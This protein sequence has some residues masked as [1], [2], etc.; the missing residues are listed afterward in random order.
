MNIVEITFDDEL[1]IMGKFSKIQNHSE[2][3]G[4]EVDGE[5]SIRQGTSYLKI[6][7]KIEKNDSTEKQISKQIGSN[8]EVSNSNDGFI[9]GFL[10]NGSYVKLDTF[11][12]SRSADSYPGFRTSQYKIL[13]LTFFKFTPIKVT[14]VF[15]FYKIDI[16][17][18]V[19]WGFFPNF[20]DDKDYSKIIPSTD[21]GKF[22]YSNFSFNLK[23]QPGILFKRDENNRHHFEIFHQL[24]FEVN[25]SIKLN[26]TSI[27]KISDELNKLISIL[28]YLPSYVSSIQCFDNTKRLLSTTIST[29]E[30]IKIPR[31]YL[32]QAESTSYFKLENE[33]PNILNSFLSRNEKLSAAISSV[34]ANISIRN[35]TESRLVNDCSTIDILEKSGTVP[36]NHKSQYFLAKIKR[37]TKSLPQEIQ[38]AFFKSDNE[39]LSFCKKVKDTRNFL[40]HGKSSKE[41]TILKDVD[42]ISA[43]ITLDWL[44]LAYV[45]N[46]LHIPL[47]NII[48]FLSKQRLSVSKD[49]II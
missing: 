24:K 7:G 22:E 9:Y 11:F 43:S 36:S 32:P 10:E 15:E 19:H 49:E 1:D 33:F 29:H 16:N 8:N 18:L 13:K 21:L 35:T 5:L 39:R 3:D 4:T 26:I 31:K 37:F 2:W 45:Y 20:F 41:P 48:D 23:L 42:L 6:L 17:N 14:D 30:N 34:Y 47:Q 25:P 46:E 27:S 38:I 28:M 40:V 12:L 44:L